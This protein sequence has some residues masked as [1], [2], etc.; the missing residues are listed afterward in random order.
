MS[1]MICAQGMPVTTLTALALRTPPPHVSVTTA[2]DFPNG[3]QHQKVTGSD[4]SRQDGPDMTAYRPFTITLLLAL[5]GCASPPAPD[6]AAVERQAEQALG[7]A[8]V[9]TISFS[10][11]GTGS[12]FGQAW[13]PGIAWPALN[14]AVLTRVVDFDN[15]ALREDFAR[16]RGEVNGGGATPLMGQGEARAVGFVRD[17]IA[18]NGA[19]A[20]AAAAP[21][22]LEARVHDLWTTT[23]QGAIQAARRYGATAGTRSLDGQSYTTLSFTVPKRLTAVVFVDAAG[24]VP[25]IESRM[26]HP[27]MGDFDV[28]TTFTDYR[29]VAGLKFPMRIR[30]SQGGFEVLDIAVQDVKAN[31]AADITVPDAM[32]SARDNAPAQQVADGVW[33][34]GGGSHNSVAVELAEQI[35]LVESPLYDGRAAATFATANALVPGKTVRT[36]INSHHHFDHAGG[37]RYAVAEGTTLITSAMAKPYFERLFANPNRINPDR[38]AQSGATPKII[39]VDGKLVLRDAARPIE[40]Y[41]MQ[42]SVHA[43]GFMMVYLPRQ[44]LLIEADAYT[45]GAPNSPPPPAPNANNVN[46]VQ[47]IERLNLQVDTL[48]PLHGRVVPASELYAAIGRPR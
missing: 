11:R 20:A 17:D 36:V 37:L 5:A 26:P 7:G 9:K 43:Q 25:R 34:I 10:G 16:S 31:V 32:R 24:L 40:I 13:Q 29:D 38:L 48:L 4:I 44:K 12:T 47:N 45:P 22:A 27:V 42:G 28:V 33:F 21:V 18:W 35:V 23:P 19:G 41:E 6:P 8:G 30:Q 2:V 39:P 14:Y 1:T 46:L 15:S 3:G